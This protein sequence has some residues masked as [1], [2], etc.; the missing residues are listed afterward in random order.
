MLKKTIHR[1]LNTLVQRTSGWIITRQTQGMKK[2]RGNI[3]LKIIELG[4]PASL[5]PLGISIWHWNWK[6][7]A[8]FSLMKLGRM[9]QMSQKKIDGPRTHRVKMVGTH[10]KR[11]YLWMYLITPPLLFWECDNLPSMGQWN[12]GL[13][14]NPL[15]KTYPKMQCGRRRAPGCSALRSGSP[16]EGEAGTA[17]G[18]ARNT[19]ASGSGSGDAFKH[20]FYHGVKIICDPQNIRPRFPSRVCPWCICPGQ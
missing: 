11:I 20:T 7:N 12:V 18:G 4:S 8:I 15:S 19:D 3:T 2:I 13:K 17:W 1:R 6:T 16:R 14:S 5:F 9:S 10:E